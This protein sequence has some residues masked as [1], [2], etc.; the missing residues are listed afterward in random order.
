ML[1]SYCIINEKWIQNGRMI[2][3]FPSLVH[4]MRTIILECVWVGRVEDNETV[5]VMLCQIVNKASV[6]SYLNRVSTL[7]ETVIVPITSTIRERE[8]RTVNGLCRER[9]S[10]DK[11][12]TYERK[13]HVVNSSH[14]SLPKG[15]T[16]IF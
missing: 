14:C 5:T 10:E 3:L 13:V 2:L 7:P 12:Y 8:Y 9:N 11:N 6:A 15:R 16:K 1:C 4:E